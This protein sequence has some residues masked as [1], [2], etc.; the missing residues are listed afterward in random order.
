[1]SVFS[2]LS[3][4]LTVLR[5]ILHDASDNYFTVASKTAYLNQAM[6]TRDRDTGMN[7]QRNNFTLTAGTSSYLLTSANANAYDINGI[8]LFNGSWRVQL[9]QRSYTDLQIVYQSVTSW[10][11]MP[12]A[13]AKYAAGSIIFAPI[14]NQPYITEWD[15]LLVSPALVNLTDVDPLPYPWTDPVPYLAAHFA[16]LEI[17][18]YDEADRMLKIYSDRIMGVLAGARGMMIKAPYF[19]TEAP[20]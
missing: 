13:F 5:R 4:Y 7:R 2:A 9:E 3:D 14:P 11:Q 12:A 17:Q 1:M 6:Q 16:N 20:Q 8:G 10:Q 18:K 19:S 15:C